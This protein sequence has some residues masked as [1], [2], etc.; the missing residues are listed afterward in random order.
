MLEIINRN[1]RFSLIALLRINLRDWEIESSI[2][3]D[4]HALFCSEESYKGF[5][6][7]GRQK[8]LNLFR[9]LT[10]FFPKGNG[11]NLD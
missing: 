3:V 10:S 6:T 11:E 4:D 8:G 7:F 2:M 5:S 1:K 9:T